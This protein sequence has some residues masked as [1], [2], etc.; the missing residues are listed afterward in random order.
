MMSPLVGT[1][2][3]VAI[4]SGIG[5]EH[6]MK[7]CSHGVIGRREKYCILLIA[8]VLPRRIPL[9]LQVIVDG[10]VER[11][12]VIAILAGAWATVNI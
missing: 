7:S 11:P 5:E 4:Y 10:M 9:G 6:S 1:G 3:K 12:I 8:R 2:R